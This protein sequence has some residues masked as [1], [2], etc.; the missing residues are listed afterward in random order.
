LKTGIYA[1]CQKVLPQLVINGDGEKGLVQSCCSLLLVP[2]VNP[3]DYIVTEEDDPTQ[4]LMPMV[5]IILTRIMEVVTITMMFEK[6]YADH[7]RSSRG[8]KIALCFVVDDE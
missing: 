6:E 3:D 1:Q 5:M 8:K 4:T 7:N 2:I